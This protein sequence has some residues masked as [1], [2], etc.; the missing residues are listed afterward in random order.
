MNADKPTE[1][2]EEVEVAVGKLLFTAVQI[3]HR[4]GVD[5]EKALGDECDRVVADAKD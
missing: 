2:P 4:L 5:P 1:T 3:A